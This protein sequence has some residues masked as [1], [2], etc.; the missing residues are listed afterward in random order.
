MKDSYTT[1]VEKKFLRNRIIPQGRNLIGLGGPDIEEYVAFARKK[2][3]KDIKVWE[4]N[5]AVWQNCLSKLK[6]LNI[7]YNVADIINAPIHSNCIYDLDF[8]C[9]I[10]RVKPYVEKF[11]DNFVLT[12]SELYAKKLSSVPI[13]ADYR[14]EVIQKVIHIND[15][16]HLLLTNLGKYMVYSY[17]DTSQMLIIKPLSIS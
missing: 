8:C 14:N 11:R 1:S 10:K 12:V 17:H 2:G 3:Y 4:N 13:F 6:N 15:T 7:E 9:S 5:P 16:D